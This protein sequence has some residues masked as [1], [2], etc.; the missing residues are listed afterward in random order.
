MTTEEGVVTTDKTADELVGR[1]FEATLGL[2]DILSI[3]LGDRLG[4]Y[5]ALH[6][7]G[8]DDGRRSRGARRDRPPLRPRVAGAAGRHRHPR[9]GRCLG[10]RGR[11]S[12]PA[13]GCVRGSAARHRQP[14]DRAARPVG[15]LVR[16]RHA[17]A[18]G[19]VPDRWRRGL[20]RLR[21]RHDRVAGRLQPALAH[22]FVRLRD[23]AGDPG[24]RRA[25][26]RG[27]AG[28]GRGCRLWRRLGGDRD[29]ACLP[30]GARRRLRPRS[31]RPSNSPDRMPETRASTIA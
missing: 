1:V 9:G 15:R 4:L 14:V 23:A 20:V 31:R 27:P 30:D 10:R 24:H 17:P 29:R 12:I 8:R 2:M 18:D 26:G 28:A 21:P 22:G 25:P 3:Y 11:A 16:Q 19:R 13:A 7:S 6:D 5:R